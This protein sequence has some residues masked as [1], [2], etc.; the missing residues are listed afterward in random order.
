M[1]GVEVKII[2]YLWL[3]DYATMMLVRRGGRA[4]IVDTALEDALTVSLEPA[5]R[6]ARLR[7]QDIMWV[8][9]THSHDDHVGCNAA[10]KKLTPAKFAVH[11]AGAEKLRTLGTPPDLLLQDGMS[12]GGDD[13][14]LTVI[15]TPGH[16]PDSVSLLE[17]ST[18]TLFAGDAVQGRGTVGGGL[19]L[20]GDPAAYCG[21]IQ[22]LLALYH[23]GAFC[24][25]VLSHPFCPSD[26][27]VEEAMIAPF[28]QGCLDTVKWYR[29]AV[30][31]ALADNPELSPGETRTLLLGRCGA[32]LAPGWAELSSGTA[33]V[34]L[35]FVRKNCLR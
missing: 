8:V 31:E 21:S 20:F 32:S 17:P 1:T 10:L 34:M 12:V 5:L 30:T 9:N 3:C 18:G 7:W 26:G 4:M 6:Q 22:K 35:Q 28:L 2:R 24:R 11:P 19:A 29:D 15:G 16:S 27:E 14:P 25:L 23:D 13:L 33:R